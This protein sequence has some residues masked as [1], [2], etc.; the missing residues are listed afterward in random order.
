M[1][2]SQHGEVCESKPYVCSPYKVS[3]QKIFC[4]SEDFEILAFISSNFY[5]FYTGVETQHQLLVHFYVQVRVPM[6]VLHDLAQEVLHF[7][8]SYP[9][10][11][12]AKTV[13]QILW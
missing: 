2:R 5:R 4:Y 10:V 7:F 1:R 8:N 6:N 3:L 13:L 12:I 11:V 9:A